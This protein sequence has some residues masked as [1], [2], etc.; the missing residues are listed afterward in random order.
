MPMERN[1]ASADVRRGVRCAAKLVLLAIGIGCGSD[2]GEH[3][4]SAEFALTFPD[5]W[6]LR[7]NYRDMPLVAVAPA[8]DADAFPVNLNVRLVGNPDGASLDEFYRNHFDEDIA[9]AVHEN[10]ERID[11]SDRQVGSHPAKR[12]VYTHRIAPDDLKSV[13]WLVLA[14]QRGYI[15]TGN[16]ALAQFNEY[17]PIFDQVAT[18]LAAD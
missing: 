14:G 10:F 2:P 5:G 1:R 16:A 17:E 18:S 4:Y 12:V 6:K 13:A 11:V 15:I 3:R 9:R 7:E 8:G